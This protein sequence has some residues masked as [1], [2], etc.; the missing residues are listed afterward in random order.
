MCCRAVFNG[1]GTTDSWP[2]ASGR[3]NWP[4]AANCW[5]NPLRLSRL[6]TR[7][8]TI[9]TA[10]SC[11]PESR[12]GTARI[13]V[14]VTWCASRR[15]SR[16][17]AV[18]HEIPDEHRQPRTHSTFPQLLRETVASF[19]PNWAHATET[20]GCRVY[21]VLQ[22]HS[23]SKHGQRFD[24]RSSSLASPSCTSTCRS[25]SIPIAPPPVALV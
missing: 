20:C 14:K 2:T 19:W 21:F 9:A 15:F 13:A 18:R 23:V 5:P 7:L 25:D 17:R 22:D 11:S 24:V 6:P 1:F 3:S 12:C 8:S 4:C 10:T 16:A